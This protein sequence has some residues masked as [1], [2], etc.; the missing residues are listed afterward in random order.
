MF[1][2]RVSQGL[3]VQGEGSSQIFPMVSYGFL[4][5]PKVPPCIRKP[6]MSVWTNVFS[7][8]P[9]LC[10]LGP[11]VWKKNAPMAQKT[12]MMKRFCLALQNCDRS[13]ETTG[14]FKWSKGSD[15]VQFLCS[16]QQHTW[17]RGTQIMKLT[18]FQTSIELEHFWQVSS[19]HRIWLSV[20]SWETLGNSVLPSKCKHRTWSWYV[21]VASP[22]P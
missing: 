6:I 1:H 16:S 3:V 19:N 10:S 22:N 9:D 14:Q 13:W 11:Q 20:H 4:T 8:P 7:K 18:L 2:G 17:H 12:L 15:V 21:D 5:L